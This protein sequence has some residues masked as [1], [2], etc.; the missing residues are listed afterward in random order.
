VKHRLLDI[1]AVPDDVRAVDE[2]VDVVRGEAA[3]FIDRHGLDTRHQPAAILVFPHFDYLDC[4]DLLLPAHRAAKPVLVA[5][6]L[7]LG[8]FF[9]GYDL[10]GLRNPGFR[11]GE[12]PM[13]MLVIRRMVKQD[14]DFLSEG[15]PDLL[16]HYEQRFGDR[17]V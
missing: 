6:G 1:A 7:M 3:A 14:G 5:Q 12:A 2:I 16:H 13:P 9:P 15:S 11:A 4:M 8:E 17:V 10:A